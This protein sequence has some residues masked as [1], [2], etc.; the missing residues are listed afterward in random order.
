[1]H[2]ACI[3]DTNNDGAQGEAREGRARTACKYIACVAF[4]SLHN[5]CLQRSGLIGYNDT[6]L[7]ILISLVPFLEHGT[8]AYRQRCRRCSQLASVATPAVV[9]C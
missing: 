3:P 4:S 9:V 8:R 7:V 5:S 1:M 2:V 6:L